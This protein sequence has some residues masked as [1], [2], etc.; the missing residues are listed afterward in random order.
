MKGDVANPKERQVSLYNFVSQ[1]KPKRHWTCGA[2]GIFRNASLQ[3][4]TRSSVTIQFSLG[5]SFL[6]ANAASLLHV[7]KS[8]FSRG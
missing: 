4:L 3:G 2:T 5:I 8:L 1:E 6:M 7:S